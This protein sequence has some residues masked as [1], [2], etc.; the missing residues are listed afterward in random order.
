MKTLKTGFPCTLLKRF[1]T[2]FLVKASYS[3]LKTAM[4]L[5]CLC[6]QG[7]G[8]SRTSEPNV[9]QKTWILFRD[10]GTKIRQNGKKLSK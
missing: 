3:I 10:L 1:K 4:N 5:E 7:L 8:C 9:A 2:P 6:D